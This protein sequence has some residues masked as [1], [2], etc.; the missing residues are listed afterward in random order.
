MA[1]DKTSYAVERHYD[2]VLNVGTMVAGAVVGPINVNISTVAPFVWRGCAG[3]SITNSGGA[4]ET[5]AALPEYFLS[6]WQDPD[7][8]YLQPIRVPDMW[9]QTALSRAVPLRR[10]MTCPAGSTIQVEFENA[11]AG[12][13]TGVVVVLRGVELYPVNCLGGKVYSPS[14]PSCYQSRPFQY[15][16]DLSLVAGATVRDNVM[17]IRDDA[18]FV[19]RG[20][21]IE[22][23]AS[24]ANATFNTLE[25]R[26]M[27]ELKKPYASDWLRA[28]VLC[29]ADAW[30][31]G[32][33]YPEIYIER[34]HQFLFDARN[35]GAG[36]QV[37]AVQL[38]FDGAKIF[39][40]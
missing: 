40:T 25:L 37:T 30:R 21:E 6:R 12:T 29:G 27:D 35:V 1:T 22:A 33:M 7:K 19:W 32:L 39:R 17:N 20:T 38:A 15:V 4:S 16:A 2:Y 28:E 14:Y 26:F 9:T 31:P 23:D 11:T 13:L 3:Y 34:S 24:T 36:G 5:V 18:D 10:H 8:N